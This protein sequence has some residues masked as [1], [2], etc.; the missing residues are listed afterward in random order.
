M[1]G[2]SLIHPQ[3]VHD[4]FLIGC[5]KNELPQDVDMSKIFKAPPLINYYCMRCSGYIV[6]RLK[7]KWN[8]NNNTFVTVDDDFEDRANSDKGKLNENTSGIENNVITTKFVPSK[9]LDKIEVTNNPIKDKNLKLT[10]SKI[11]N[12]MDVDK[13]LNE[14][15]KLNL[16]NTINRIDEFALST[17]TFLTHHLLFGFSLLFAFLFVIF[18][19]Q[20]SREQFSPSDDVD[21]DHIERK[22]RMRRKE[23]RRRNR[24]WQ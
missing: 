23:M 1:K 9:P 21:E 6:D 3:L 5:K 10:T 20:R 16:I 4:T 2:N 18:L 11:D 12:R 17:W 14:S 13:K 7:D 8:F 22:G 19:C 15:N 24:R